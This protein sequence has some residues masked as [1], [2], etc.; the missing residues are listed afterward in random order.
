MR[1]IRPI[2]AGLLALGLA[3]GT[4]SAALGKGGEAVATFD[5]PLPVDAA[6][7]TTVRIGWTVTMTFDDGSVH[8]LLAESVFIRLTPPKGEPIEVPARSDRDG[9]FVATVHRPVRRPRDRGRRSPGRCVP[10]ERRV[11]SGRRLLPDRRHAA[12]GGGGR[13]CARA[14]RGSPRDPL[15]PGAAAGVDPALAGE[16]AG[17]KPSAAAINPVIAPAATPIVSVGGA[18]ELAPLVIVAAL[19]LVSL[20]LG[21]ALRGRR[22]QPTM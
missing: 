10:G 3:L 19:V 8:P 15:R 20:G 1:R 12:L 18:L 4:S 5:T 2:V 7:G 9:H 21:L 16:A 17:A 22:P 13:W 11:H 14:V 6:P